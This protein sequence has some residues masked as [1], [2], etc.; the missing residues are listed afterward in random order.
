VNLEKRG[1]RSLKPRWSSRAFQSTVLA[2]SAT[3][4]LTACAATSTPAAPEA[5]ADDPV[6]IGVAMKTQ[7][8]ERWAFDVASMQAEADA[9]GATLI[10]QYADDD[11]T[12][13]ASQVENLLSQGI[14]VLIMVPVD[15]KAAA[16]S[17]NAANAAGVPVISYDIG[18]QGVAVDAFVIRNNPQVGVLQAE[19]CLAATGGTGN[20]V[21]IWGDAANDVAQ[22]ISIG[23]TAT[24]EGTEANVLYADFNKNWD[25]AT[26]Q[27]TAENLLTAN[28]DDIKAFLTANDGMAGGVIQALQGRGLGGKVCVTGLDATPTAL[29]FILQD[30]MTMSV[31]TPIDKQAQLAVQAA[32]ALANGEEIAATTTTDN[33]SGAEIPTIQV[34]V[35]AIT[36]DKV[37]DFVRTIAPEGW[38]KAEDVFEDISVCPAN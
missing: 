19:T 9:Q 26:A 22:A 18:V 27:A 36:K 1:I 7:L 13:Q 25:P 38:V 10:V 5:P 31:W 6:V 35:E 16:A 28:N 23:Q 3:L 12:L 15:D 21:Q 24:L 30:L 2:M 34:P 32:L 37:C 20:Y 4:A 17:A 11:A 8:Q 33:G 29:K 14:D